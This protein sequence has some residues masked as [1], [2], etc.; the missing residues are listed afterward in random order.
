MNF[1]EDNK[2]KWVT[3]KRRRRRRNVDKMKKITFFRLTLCSIVE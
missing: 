3:K 1:V 2:I